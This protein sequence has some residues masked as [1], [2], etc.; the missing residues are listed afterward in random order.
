MSDPD[1]RRKLPHYLPNDAPYFITT[2]LSGS[3]SK[4]EEG[5]LLALRG[6]VEEGKFFDAF[7]LAL[8]ALHGGVDYLQR[9][10]VREIVRAKLI[11]LDAELHLIHLH[12]FCI[13]PNHLHIVMSIQPPKQKLFKIMKLLKGS[14]A[15]ESNIVLGRTGRH[16][17]QFESYDHVVRTGSLGRIIRY[18]IMNPVKAGLVGDWTRWPGTYLATGLDLGLF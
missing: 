5:R 10:A 6:T 18:V 16:F 15:R 4:P 12:A 1:Y 3:L 17:W 2:R 7:D 13:M 14:T 11:A 8:N 9:P